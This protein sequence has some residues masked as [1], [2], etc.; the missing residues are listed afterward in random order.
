MGVNQ[1]TGL[2][3]EEFEQVYLGAIPPMDIDQI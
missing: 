3:Q 1:F 2:T